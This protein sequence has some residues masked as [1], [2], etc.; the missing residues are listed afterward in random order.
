[1]YS[2]ER[3]LVVGFVIFDGFELLD[4]FGPVE[5]LTMLRERSKVVMLA[6]KAGP[7]TGSKGVVVM[8]DRALSDAGDIDVLIVP[9]GMGTRREVNN[10]AL[11][12]TLR[13]L[14]A[15]TPMVGSVCTGSALLAKAGML[16]GVQ[17]T[18]NKRA[19]AWATSQ[20]PQVVWVPRARWIEDGKY[21]TSSGVSA[22]MDMTLGLIAKLFD[23]E[24]ARAC[25]Q[26]AEYVWAEDATVDPFAAVNGL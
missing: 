26:G 23:V 24:T 16:D 12:A 4:V 9:G 3:P 13:D 25:A 22:G 8:A 21:I 10:E 18:T 15:K 19:Y 14:G 17:A 5:M 7:I 11:L 20:G 1:M 2:A 6:E